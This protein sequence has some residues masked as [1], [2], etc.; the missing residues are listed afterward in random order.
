MVITSLLKRWLQMDDGEGVTQTVNDSI[1]AALGIDACFL[2]C[3]KANYPF[4]KDQLSGLE[5]LLRILEL[6]IPSEMLSRNPDALGMMQAVSRIYWMALCTWREQGACHV[7]IEAL[8]S[9]GET[10]ESWP[11]PDEEIL[12]KAAQ[13]FFSGRPMAQIL[14]NQLSS[15][16]WRSP[17]T[18][19]RNRDAS[20]SSIA[21]ALMM[22]YV[23]PCYLESTIEDA[24][25]MG[26]EVPEP[27]NFPIAIPMDLRSLRIR[28]SISIPPNAE[29]GDILHDV[30]PGS[31][32]W[33]DLEIPHREFSPDEPALR[34]FLEDEL[35]SN[36]G[37]Q[38]AYEALN[39]E[40]WPEIVL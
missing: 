25:R 21:I 1:Y 9:I 35:T 8:N 24:R 2:D 20:S 22:A 7:D 36:S 39:L 33:L 5:Q 37:L 34:D 12:N 13:G 6:G 27:E 10:I 23:G 40:N 19:L 28:H 17:Y 3:S 15:R 38:Q 31:K 29:I 18:E 11:R 32:A 30:L 14:W 4:A 16:D 26:V